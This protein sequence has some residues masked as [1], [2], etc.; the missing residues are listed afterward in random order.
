MHAVTAFAASKTLVWDPPPTNTDG[1]PPTD[2]VGYKIYYGP[3]SGNYTNTLDVGKVTTSVVNNLTNGITYYFAVTAYN[4]A[5]V[6]SSFSNEVS[7]TPPPQSVPALGL[8]GM[9]ATAAVLAGYAARKR[10]KR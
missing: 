6:E 3:K 4:S 7:K 9:M 2:L 8:W 1:T 10:R 5:R